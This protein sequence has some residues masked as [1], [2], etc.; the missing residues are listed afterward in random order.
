MFDTPE[1]AQTPSPVTL[2]EELLD[3]VTHPI[4]GPTAGLA[5]ITYPSM[6]VYVRPL[7]PGVFQGRS[8]RQSRNEVKYVESDEGPLA[9]NQLSVP[10]D[11][12]TYTETIHLIMG[13]FGKQ[14]DVI[15]NELGTSYPTARTHRQNLFSKLG[16]SSMRHAVRVSFDLGILKPIPET[17]YRGLIGVTS[18]KLALLDMVSTGNTKEEVGE[19]FGLSASTVRTHL[20]AIH[21]KNNLHDGA[22]A[23]M[24]AC[25]AGQLPLKQV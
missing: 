6:K 18:H 16:A 11:Y 5:P 2:E 13:G 9:V 25:L 24:R 23:V 10:H 3:R 17:K 4:L 15:A 12:L 20:Q 1:R 22:H 8:I 14:M 7:E 21:N 19:K